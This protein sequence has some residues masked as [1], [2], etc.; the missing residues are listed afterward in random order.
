M[1]DPRSR[2]RTALMLGTVFLAGVAIGPTSGLIARHVGLGFVVNGA[3]AQNSDRADTYRLLALFGDAFER[4]RLEYVDPVSDK[5]LIEYAIGGMLT[6][7]DPHSGYM[8]A[9]KFRE[10]KI[11]ITGQFAGLGIEVTQEN[12]F[13][14]V[15]SPMD[16]TPASKAGIRAGDIITALNGK[17]VQWLSLEDALEEM[18]GA[19]NS[20]VTLTIRREGVDR[21][22]E[23]SMRREIIHLP[24]V[25]QRMEPD[26]IGYVRLSE[27][28]EQADAALKQAVRSLRQQ[29]GGKL[30]ALILDL[31]NNPGGLLDQAVAISGDFI[32]QGAI[33][34]TRGRD[35][36]D[37]QWLGVKGND[38]LRGAPLVVLINAGSASASEI[39][40]GA[41]QDRHR[42]VLVGTRSFG[43]GS[44]QTVIP[45]P[46]N[47]GIRLTTGRYY[48]PSGR[49]IQGLG[50]MPDVPVFGGPRR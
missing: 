47:G 21:P 36:E 25:T 20:K 13:V 48:T 35:A 39:V 1:H 32:E 4:V 49:S 7:L 3:F 23:I 37:T 5:S 12:G 41:L 2:L 30:N 9:A 34:S 22:L 44:L 42:A 38:I 29:A 27:F 26:K 19:P 10:M 11:Q 45:L 24:V 50:I 8:N 14:K 40:A 33:V 16:G 18:R 43:K 17:T 6:G 28:T 46:G 15:V 31:R